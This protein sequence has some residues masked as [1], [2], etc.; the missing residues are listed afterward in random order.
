MTVERV[1]LNLFRVFE[2]IMTH[3]SMAGA[4]R[5]L[6]ITASAVSHAL[7][8]LRRLLGDELFKAGTTG[9]QPTPRATELAPMIRQ[10]LGAIAR[11]LDGRPF[12]PAET[13]RSFAIAATD[14]AGTILLPGIIARVSSAAPHASLRIVPFGHPSVVQQLDDGR[15]DLLIGWFDKLPSRMRRQTLLQD[16]EAIVV[17]AGHPLTEGPV[18]RERLF[19]FPHVVVELTGSESRNEDGFA[20]ERGVMRRVWIERLLV[21]TSTND[22]TFVARIAA[23]VP[24]YAAVLP[25]IE[26]TD[27]VATLP[28][29]LARSAARHGRLVMLELPYTP[30]SVN[31]EAVWHERGETDAALCWLLGEVAAAGFEVKQADGML[32]P[33]AQ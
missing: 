9:M 8:R 4:G 13:I 23:T 3:K 30:L 18:T 15:I 14:Y 21:E 10:G 31:V 11:V 20:E 29:R 1:D 25:S 5:E 28:A 19:S 24:N 7:G 32:H 17:R 12:E 27:M 22:K 6:G 2:A 26:A 16:H 33:V